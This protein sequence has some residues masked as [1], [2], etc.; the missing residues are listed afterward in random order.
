[1]SG[2]RLVACLRPGLE[3]VV[4]PHKSVAELGVIGRA[5]HM[6]QIVDAERDATMAYLDDIVIDR[7]GRRGRAQERTPTG[8]LTW[9]VSRH[10]T[11]RA[12][13]PLKPVLQSDTRSGYSLS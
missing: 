13:D 6:H 1:V 10:A 5:E 11:T 7:G 3:L 2:E 12:G 8:G 9:A 4:S